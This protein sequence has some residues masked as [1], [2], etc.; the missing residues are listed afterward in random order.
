MAWARCHGLYGLH[1]VLLFLRGGGC[2]RGALVP[3]QRSNFVAK[4]LL[5]SSP[6]LG[7]GKIN[8]VVREQAG[9]GTIELHYLC[10]DLLVT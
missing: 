1:E 7:I 4:T 3:N 9:G 2:G 6:Q 10:P 8:Q 5:E